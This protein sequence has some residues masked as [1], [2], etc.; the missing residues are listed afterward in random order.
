MGKRNRGKAESTAKPATELAI[1]TDDLKG[2]DGGAENRKSDDNGN[3]A[4]INLASGSVASA[5]QSDDGGSGDSTAGDSGERIK[6][7]YTKRGS[8]KGKVDLTQLLAENLFSMHAFMAGMTGKPI[9]GIEQTEADQLGD[10]IN[11]VAR[12]YN[13]PGVDQKTVDYI[14]LVRV[15]GMVYGT[16]LFAARVSTKNSSAKAPSPDSV[17]KPAPA[18]GAPQSPPAPRI[19]RASP[20]PGLPD[21]DVLIQ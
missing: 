6:R 10:A 16:R 4:V 1:G 2:S 21:V 3:G 9:W 19:V 7:K 5:G 12:H 18:P 11:G 14:R 17:P 8:E 20:G 13:I 15:L